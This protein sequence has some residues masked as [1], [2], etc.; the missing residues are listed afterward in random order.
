ME[1]V[2]MLLAKTQTGEPTVA[3]HN[4]ALEKLSDAINLLN[5]KAQKSNNSSPGSPS[6]SDEMA[7]LMAMM[8]QQNPQPGMQGGMKPGMNMNGG[9]TDM[10]ANAING[11]AV[12]KAAAARSSRKAGGGTASL[13]AEFRDA[14]ENYYKALEK[15]SE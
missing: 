5:E 10:P 6:E 8:Q 12:G 14:L 2:E 15:G 1:R 4:V 11:N 3:A 7:F 9:T 13:P